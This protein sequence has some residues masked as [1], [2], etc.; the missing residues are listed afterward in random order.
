M[1]L[2]NEY[3]IKNIV[4]KSKKKGGGG[5]VGVVEMNFLLFMETCLSMVCASKNII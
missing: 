5:G 4:H 3:V 1:F 2:F